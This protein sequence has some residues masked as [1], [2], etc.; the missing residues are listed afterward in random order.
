VTYGDNTVTIE[1]KRRVPLQF[2]GSLELVEEA[3]HN[4]I[5]GEFVEE[6]VEEIKEEYDLDIKVDEY[7]SDST[8]DNFVGVKF[9]DYLIP[10]NEQK[11]YTITA[12]YIES[13]TNSG[14]KYQEL[15]SGTYFYVFGNE[16][17]YDSNTC[18][19]VTITATYRGNEL[20]FNGLS[21]D[22]T[23]PCFV[24]KS[25]RKPN[26]NEISQKVTH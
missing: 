23:Y 6:V 26:E 9:N 16:F 19:T 5:R 13:T 17:P 11:D 8:P 4:D 18:D 10:E 12:K 20:R 7:S 21:M 24:I 25:I 2:D 14:V 22:N 15:Y 3:E 1:D